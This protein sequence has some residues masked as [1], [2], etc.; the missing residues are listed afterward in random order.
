MNNSG[1]S[2]LEALASQHLWGHFT[3]LPSVQH[4]MPIIDHGEGAY[5]WDVN[6]KKYLDGLAGLF[7]VQ[8]GHGRQEL[9]DAVAEQT[10]KLAYFPVWSY[11]TEPVIELAAKL[12]STAPGDLNRVFFT[13]GGGEAVES[14]W[15]LARQYFLA[16][17]QPRRTKVISRTMAYHG[18]GFGALSI[19]GVPA[20]KMPFEPLVPGAI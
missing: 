5:V 1:G 18:T 9:V 14:A 15:K 17:G 2:R 19:T 16:I 12:A 4:S 20:I 11:G 8:V 6:G 3:H 13:G 10:K 7:T